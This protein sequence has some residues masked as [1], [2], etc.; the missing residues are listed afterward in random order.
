M[1]STSTID[2]CYSNL[3]K[4]EKLKKGA[5][6]ANVEKY[7]KQIYETLDKI[8]ELT[9]NLE[10]IIIKAEPIA[11]SGDTFYKRSIANDVGNLPEFNGESIS[12]TENFLNKLD[13]LYQLLVVDI[14]SSL[15]PFFLNNIF[16]RLGHSVY[17][18][19]KSKKNKIETFAEFKIFVKKNFGG[20]LNA[21]Q[22]V[23]RIFDVKNDQDDKFHV[24]TGR[25]TEELETARGAIESHFKN[26]N[27]SETELTADQALDF[28]GALIFSEKLK[29][30]HFHIFK[31]IT[32]DFDK[33]KNCGDVATRAEYFRERLSGNPITENTLLTKNFTPNFAPKLKIVKNKRKNDKVEEKIENVAESN[34]TIE[35]SFFGDPSPF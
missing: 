27:N 11:H 9:K 16:R 18:A 12:E 13:Q 23:S 22:S 25:L 8:S 26:I 29:G 28:M 3:T 15:E 31:D 6:D 20:Q 1:S 4:L 5:D 24:Y 32:V 17:K 30:S 19:L 21:F 10:N 35:N 2:F 14:D 34:H 7:D 33:F